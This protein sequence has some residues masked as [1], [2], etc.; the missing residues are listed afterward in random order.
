MEIRQKGEYNGIMYGIDDCMLFSFPIRHNS[1]IFV[2]LFGIIII[3][4][5]LLFQ[6]C[7]LSLLAILLSLCLTSPLLLIT[8]YQLNIYLAPGL[9]TTSCVQVRIIF[10]DSRFT[11]EHHRIG[12]QRK[13]IFSIQSCASS[14]SS[15]FHAFLSVSCTKESLIQYPHG[16]HRAFLHTAHQG[17]F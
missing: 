6:A 13:S 10:S 9:I 1:T 14:F 4:S 15:Y 2:I 8:N 17:G 16:M 12:A 5:L 7:F 11:I 3:I